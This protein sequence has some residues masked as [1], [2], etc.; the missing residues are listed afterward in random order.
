ML[1]NAGWPREEG[2]FRKKHVVNAFLVNMTMSQLN[3]VGVILGFSSPEVALRLLTKGFSARDWANTSADYFKDDLDPMDDVSNNE[4]VPAWE[5]LNPI[6]GIRPS[7]VKQAEGTIPW[8]SL[9]E[10][11]WE[12]NYTIGFYQSIT[13]ALIHP[14]EAEIQLTIDTNETLTGMKEAEQHGV[15]FEGEMPPSVADWAVQTQEI[16]AAYESEAGDLPDI[17]PSLLTLPEFSVRVKH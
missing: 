10:P 5:T 3:R 9:A 12:G 8:E 15:E 11:Q 2:R 13:W 4:G 1:N 17:E 14:A 7:S 16:V 6:S